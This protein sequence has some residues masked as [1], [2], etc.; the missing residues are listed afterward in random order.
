MG[1]FNDD[2]SGDFSTSAAAV[3]DCL[4]LVKD[5]KAPGDS[6]DQAGY[7]QE[8]AQSGRKVLI[9][10]EPGRIFYSSQPLLMKHGTRF[11]GE[12]V[13][14]RIGVYPGFSGDAFIRGFSRDDGE[15]SVSE[16]VGLDS[17]SL[18]SFVGNALALLDVTGM[19]NSLFRNLTLA[20]PGPIIGAAAV[21][22]RMSDRNP[23]GDSNKTSFFNH[24]SGINAGGPGWGTFIEYSNYAGNCN[25]LSMRGFNSYSAIGVHVVHA[26]HGVGLSLCDGYMVGNGVANGGQNKMWLGAKPL[27]LE[28]RGVSGEG[29]GDGAGFL[30]ANDAWGFSNRPT[31]IESRLRA[32]DL[33]RPTAG[34][35]RAT[36]LLPGSGT[37]E[38]FSGA[39]YIQLP[40][41][42]VL[43][44]GVNSFGWWFNGGFEGV[45]A[46]RVDVVSGYPNLPLGFEGGLAGIAFS[47]SIVAAGAVT[48]NAPL[49][50]RVTAETDY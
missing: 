36:A 24:F 25:T 45:G 33:A 1:D 3:T 39:A 30:G 31:L 2:F 50:L 40:A 28:T 23:A 35:S 21:A 6:T 17:L 19:R 10:G 4:S 18:F 44:A 48:L 41:G 26:L 29:F 7:L 15:P 42:T 46:F 22:I 8:A 49:V 11:V 13:N 37:P 20:G 43:Q 12:G 14:S 16:A 9:S 38:G 32:R 27:G 47:L 34:T 5:I